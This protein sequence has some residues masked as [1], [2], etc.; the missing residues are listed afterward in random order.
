[1]SFR[2][3]PI[4]AVASVAACMLP[5]VIIGCAGLASTG[6][7]S[8]NVT[9]ASVLLSGKTHGG[10]NPISGAT[11]DLY[12]AGTAGYGTSSVTTGGAQLIAHATS[13]TDGSFAFSKT[14]G[15]ANDNSG[16]TYTCP[17]SGDPLVYLVSRGGDTT[18]TNGSGGTGSNDASVLFTLLGPCSTDT[19]YVTI[20]EA[21]TVAATFAMQQFMS[22]TTSD[23][24]IGA[25]N[26]T[27][28]A[29]GI[30]NA[31]STF[32]NMIDPSRGVV[33]TTFT[34]SSAV[35][36]VTMTGTP[37]SVKLI[38]IANILAGCVNQVDNTTTPCTSL[39]AHAVPPTYKTTNQAVSSY[40]AAIDTAMATY[41]LAVNPTQAQDGTAR[42]T[43]LY[44]LSTANTPF[45]TGLGAAP[46]DW[47][48]GITYTAGATTCTGTATGL[49][50]PTAASPFADPFHMAIDAG[51]NIW[52]TNT[53]ATAIN[54]I[55]EVSNNG[56]VAACI[57]GSYI[58]GA[59][60]NVDYKN[61]VWVAVAG[62]APGT[63]NN[64][65][66]IANTTTTPV[67]LSL[68]NSTFQ[69]YAVA[70]GTNGD[71]WVSSYN[72][73]TSNYDIEV[74]A[75]A[76]TGTP[77]LDS[78]VEAIS[79]QP[80]GRNFGF[81]LAYPGG[82]TLPDVVLDGNTSIYPI[83]PPTTGTANYPYTYGGAGS[84]GLENG[85]GSS[86]AQGLAVDGNQY[87]VG[88]SCSSSS[89]TKVSPS[90]YA[91]WVQVQSPTVAA[92]SAQF[93][94]GM[95][96]GG[97]VAADGNNNY[98]SGLSLPVLA[99]VY[100]FA[101]ITNAATG[102]PPLLNLTTALSPG[103]A[104]T[105]VPA[106]CFNGGCLTGGGF[107]RATVAGPIVDTAIDES[108]NVWGLIS[109]TAASNSGLVEVVGA[110]APVITPIVNSLP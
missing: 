5:F 11:I 35:A 21:S 32:L 50:S 48:L 74:Y 91:T 86:A 72:K 41:Y 30:K 14:A 10:Y 96:T 24:F 89:S 12:L 77:A 110:A 6:G 29:T 7:G 22:V 1:M 31:Y 102:T 33:L 70:T 57:G 60:I 80:T 51:G 3:N 58:V 65:Y 55:T 47:T 20:N 67:A 2:F 107:Q 46:L 61:N 39:M 87:V 109:A 27:P 59:G 101:E 36:G 79:P 38:T 19:G 13:G 92:I 84:T 75:G 82:I 108:G 37:E 81:A 69:P 78:P 4:K 64:L 56:G 44:G 94:G 98:W 106:K 54:T 40:V 100:A 85:C 93:L 9:G 34:P 53:A 83:Y 8:G 71:L 49:A 105:F 104:S 90:P 17:S 42:N 68:P 95:N 103:V 26:T 45:G 88:V 23:I 62:S 25:P 16:S 97:G 52:I 43:T 28:A 18:G 15:A 73:N 99:G 76:A 63:G 66:E